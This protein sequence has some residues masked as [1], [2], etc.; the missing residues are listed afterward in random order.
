[1]N[2]RGRKSAAAIEAEL[3]RLPVPTT[4]ATGP[5]APYD[6]TDEEAKVWRGIVNTMPSS[7]F[8]RETHDLLSS[9]CRHV[10]SASFVSREITRFQERSDWITTD[11]GVA[12]LH[13]LTGIRE[14][15]ARAAQSIARSLRLTPQARYR[16]EKA[17]RMSGGFR[18][19]DAMPVWE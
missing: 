14:R 7:W 12:R 17:G 11:E 4:P 10:V 16:P 3:L 6:L 15:E 2:K 1:M 5:D 13:K 19:Y 18:G 9:Y 8:T